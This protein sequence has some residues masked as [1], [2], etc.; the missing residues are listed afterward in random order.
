MSAHNGT[1]LWAD[2]LGAINFTSE[3]ANEF[4]VRATGGFRFVTNFESDAGCTISGG[5]LT[6]TGA[7]NANMGISDRNLKANFSPV[8][9]QE[10]LARV[11]GIP[12]ET[13]NY[14]SQD[15]SIRHMG[16]M[17]QDFHAAFGL[18]VSDTSINSIDPDG[19][20]LAAVQGLN[21]ILMEKEEEL[22][23]LRASQAA[24][25][26][27]VLELTRLVEELMAGR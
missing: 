8:D 16:P 11:S 13:W 18:G 14:K 26:A 15:P 2:N 20:A 19:V 3:A 23:D 27:R 9:R 24:L 12:I 25:E 21:A 1:F 22:A 4:A 17:A 10:I 7:V 6:C 5:D